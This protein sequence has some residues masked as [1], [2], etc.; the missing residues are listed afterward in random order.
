MSWFELHTEYTQVLAYL[1][2]T[3]L[4]MLRKDF[5]FL[6]PCLFWF[7]CILR[8][9]VHKLSRSASKLDY[10]TIELFSTSCYYRWAWPSLKIVKSLIIV[11]I[12]NSIANVNLD[13][14]QQAIE[15]NGYVVEEDSGGHS[16]SKE[17]Y[18]LQWGIHTEWSRHILACCHGKQNI[19]I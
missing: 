12:R 1:P 2:L 4:L 14:W 13:R 16:G 8:S 6:R 10:I 17:D 7:G 5:T 3:L 19:T 18:M 9:A 15:L 11:I